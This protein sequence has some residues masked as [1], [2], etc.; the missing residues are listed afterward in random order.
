MEEERANVC[1]RDGNASLEDAMNDVQY[2]TWDVKTFTE[3]RRLKYRVR[4]AG[5]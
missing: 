4:E 5:T 2:G 3:I 1:M